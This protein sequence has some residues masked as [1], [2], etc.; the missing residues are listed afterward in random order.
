M[1]IWTGCSWGGCGVVM[2]EA[3]EVDVMF[4]DLHP[5]R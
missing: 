1:W 2:L 5:V 3:V 4:S